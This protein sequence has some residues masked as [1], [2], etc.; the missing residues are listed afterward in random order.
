MTNDQSFSHYELLILL[1]EGSY[2]KVWKARDIRDGREV[3]I[4]ILHAHLASQ[5]NIRARFLREADVQTKLYHP[6]IVKVFEVVEDQGSVGMVMELIKG[7][8][9]ADAIAG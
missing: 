1:G 5:E 9:M 6:N 8:T 4:K 7:K 3:A 2:A